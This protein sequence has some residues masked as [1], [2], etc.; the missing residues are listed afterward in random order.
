M[1]LSYPMRTT[2][3]PKNNSR[4]ACVSSPQYS[5]KAAKFQNFKNLKMFFF[6]CPIYTETQI[7][8]SEL[9]DKFD[10]LRYPINYHR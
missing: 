7:R 5:S 3:I 10:K 4:F 2:R 1:R 9:F 6:I 8:R